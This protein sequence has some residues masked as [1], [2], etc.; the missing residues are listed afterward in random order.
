MLLVGRESLFPADTA[1]CASSVTTLTL[2]IL[3]GKKTKHNSV[4]TCCWKRLKN[5]LKTRP[6]LKQSSC[7]VA[8]QRPPKW[9][10]LVEPLGFTHFSFTDPILLWVTHLSLAKLEAFWY[11]SVTETAALS[12]LPTAGRSRPDIYPSTSSLGMTIAWRLSC[13]SPASRLTSP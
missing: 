2:Y 8:L 6:Q 7:S 13:C 4:D 10:Q 1:W 12:V 5:D 9:A 3:S 11:A